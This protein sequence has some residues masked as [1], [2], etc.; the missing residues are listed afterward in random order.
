MKNPTRRLLWLALLLPLAGLA[1]PGDQPRTAYGH[2]DLQGTYTFRTI[3]P[4]EQPPE[5]ADKAVLTPRSRRMG[6]LRK[7]PPEPRPDYRLGGRRRLPARGDLLQRVL[8]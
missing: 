1:Q 2:P 5:L 4:L 8:V 3:T 7:P 6:S